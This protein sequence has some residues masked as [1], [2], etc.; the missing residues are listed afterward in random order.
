[1]K[2][3]YLHTPAAYQLEDLKPDN[4]ENDFEEEDYEVASVKYKFA[5]RRLLQEFPELAPFPMVAPA[6]EHDTRP[7]PC[8]RGVL[9]KWPWVVQN[10]RLGFCAGRGCAKGEWE[11]GC[12]REEWIQAGAP[13]RHS[14]L[15]SDLTQ[16]DLIFPSNAQEVLQAWA[17]GKDLA[18]A[19]GSWTQVSRGGSS[20]HEAAQM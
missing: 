14:D 4:F 12:W 5:T 19:A 13:G 15:L 20:C 2:L 17:A 9:A 7:C 16:S 11:L 1:M 10:D 8:G 18:W 3:Q 6:S